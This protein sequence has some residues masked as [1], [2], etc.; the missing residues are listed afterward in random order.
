[1]GTMHQILRIHSVPFTEIWLLNISINKR[2]E[3]LSHFAQDIPDI[4]T[5]QK[6][7]KT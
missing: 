4:N 7:T 3:L 5:V 2:K 6:S 1:M